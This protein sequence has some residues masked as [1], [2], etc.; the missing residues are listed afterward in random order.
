[1]SLFGAPIP[2]GITKAE[3]PFIK[4]E[5]RSA[6]FTETQLGDIM[7]DL[8]LALDADMS[9]RHAHQVNPEEAEQI[10][11]QAANGKG[12]KYSKTQ[13]EKLHSVLE[14]Y[15]GINKTKSLF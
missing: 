15:I 8:E 9:S 11:A 14:K 5:L 10:E 3:L 7:E 6:G 13:I 1:M 4:S 12:V 2:K